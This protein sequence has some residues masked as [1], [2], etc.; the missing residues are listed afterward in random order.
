VTEHLVGEAR[1]LDIADR[2]RRLG[3]GP[4]QPHRLHN[5]AVAA[6]RRGELEFDQVTRVYRHAALHAGALVPRDRPRFHHCPQCGAQLDV[7]E[8]N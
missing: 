3:S 7:P 2:L 5:E 4:V 8:D 6:F 1:V